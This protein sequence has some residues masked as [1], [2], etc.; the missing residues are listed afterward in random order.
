MPRRELRQRLHER[1]PD[2]QAVHARGLLLQRPRE[3]AHE[4]GREL[5]QVL[6]NED[7]QAADGVERV[8][9][10]GGV[11]RAEH[12]A[13]DVGEDGQQVL[14]KEVGQGDARVVDHNVR[15]GLQHGRDAVG[16]GGTSEGGG[17]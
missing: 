16:P 17:W 2:A 11:A 1:H 12:V 10:E 8:P 7:D 6:L 4:L 5:A 14:V 9:P 13:V 3:Q 15:D